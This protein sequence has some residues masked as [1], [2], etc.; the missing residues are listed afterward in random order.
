M[1]LENHLARRQLRAWIARQ[2]AA[3]SFAGL[4]LEKGEKTKHAADDG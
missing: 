1:R 3:F 4:L 2:G